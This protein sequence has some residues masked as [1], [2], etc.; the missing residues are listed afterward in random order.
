MRAVAP[1][2][3]ATR[4]EPTIEGAGTREERE[5][6]SGLEESERGSVTCSCELERA[7]RWRT[8]VRDGICFRDRRS[9]ADGIGSRV[10]E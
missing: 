4:D 7:G 9:A 2:S 6:P 10:G 1:R 8:G 5:L 3:V